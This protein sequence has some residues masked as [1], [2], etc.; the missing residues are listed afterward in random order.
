[1][2]PPP[3]AGL[4]AGHLDCSEVV[5][6]E[7]DPADTRI[8]LTCCGANEIAMVDGAGR[9]LW[10]VTGHHFE[11][12]DVAA[13]RDDVRG[14]QCIVDIDHVAYGES[15]LWL[16]DA[17]GTHVLTYRMGYGR[18]HRLV[19]YDGDGLED[20]VLPEA[21]RVMDG[22]GRCLGRF[23]AQTGE[24]LEIEEVLPADGDPNPL[25]L[26]GDLDGDGRREIVLHT[27]RNVWVY[28]SESVPVSACRL[29]TG[30]NWTLY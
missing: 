29:G 27:A 28:R 1:L 26:V 13:L 30:L 25:G 17:E 11:S 5:T 18:H 15:E 10:R 24:E 3:E 23:V 12:V 2:A 4:G 22:R 21:R 8:A 14:P 20:L 19:D 16:L 6:L 9:A 7:P